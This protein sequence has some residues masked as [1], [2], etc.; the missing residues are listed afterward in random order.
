MGNLCADGNQT[1][2]PTIYS[3]EY[4]N[5]AAFR[6]SNQNGHFGDQ[7]PSKANTFGLQMEKQNSALPGF[8]KGSYDE[9]FNGKC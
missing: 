2:G 5:K 4:K 9:V 7:G 8:T 1:N 3:P 6:G